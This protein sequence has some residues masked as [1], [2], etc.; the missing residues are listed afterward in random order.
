MIMFLVSGRKL[1]PFILLLIA[2]FGLVVMASGMNQ[3][4]ALVGETI[5]AQLIVTETTQSTVNTT[6]GLTSQSQTTTYSTPFVLQATQGLRGCVY[7]ALRFNASQGDQISINIKSSSEIAVHIMSTTDY[8]TWVKKNNCTVTSSLHSWQTVR[9]LFI[10]FTAPF[11]GDYELLF[12]NTS[13]DTPAS[14]NLNLVNS[15]QNVTTSR[16]PLTETHTAASTSTEVGPVQA[17]PFLDQYGLLIIVLLGLVTA[18]LALLRRSRKEGSA[19]RVARGREPGSAGRYLSP[20]PPHPVAVKACG[21]CGASIPQDARYCG[22][23]G[24][25]QR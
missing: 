10:D 23:C 18:A 11:T 16:A 4:V 12:L 14:V 2:L 20:P 1:I 6:Q 15:S 9:T 22:E 21:N 25:T 13:S 3:T 17:K 8:S 19:T 5:T 24:A 7:K